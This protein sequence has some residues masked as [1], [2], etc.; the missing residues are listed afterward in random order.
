M[1]P[2]TRAGGFSEYRGVDAL[3]M[4]LWLAVVLLSLILNYDAIAALRFPDADDP[5]RLAQV[6]DLIAGQSWF[7]IR[8]YRVNPLEGGGLMHWSRF[9]D[10]S[11]A[12]L[13]LPLQSLLGETAGERWAITLYPPLLLLPLFLLIV[14]ILGVLGDRRLVVAGLLVAFTGATFLHFFIPMRIDHH[15]WQLLLS[16]AMVWIALRPPSLV[17]GLLGAAIITLYVEISLEGLPYLLL[18]G[19][20]FAF[21]WLRNSQTSRRLTGF[22]F[23]LVGFPAL[24]LLAMRGARSALTVFCDTFSLPYAAAVA[25]S[26]AVVG[27]WTLGPASL[28]QSLWYRLFAL[29]AAGAAGATAFV[30]SGP[31]CLAGP[32]GALDPL[33]RHHW[34]DR[35]LEGRPVWADQASYGIIY[36]VP[37]LVGLAALAYAWRRS[38]GGPFAENWTRVAVIILGSALMSALV[39]RTGATTHALLVPAFATM[40]LALWDWSRSR[41]S[42]A[43]RSA[44]ILLIFAASPGADAAL[45]L[46]LVRAMSD[47]TPLMA[48]A[49][50]CPSIVNVAALGRQP[51]ARL[52]APID[53]GP[54]LLAYTPHSVVAT[55]HHR[56]NRAMHRVIS[57][58]IA[59]PAIAEP[60]V[61]AERARYLVICRGLPEVQRFASEAPHG[62][63][64]KLAR[65]ETVGWL[66][67]D[68]R[69][70]SESLDVYRVAPPSRQVVESDI[71]GKDGPVSIH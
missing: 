42:L 19:G 57:A 38:R 39:A 65:G 48:S 67:R 52:F 40:A 7:D 70:S 44:S 43:G 14:R 66:A 55:G 45:G 68:A 13:I 53:I 30:L 24:W 18:F 61:R 64:A 47:E 51:A 26:A 9:V 46:K 16:M 62:L 69:L 8:Q 22:A 1:Y 56:N 3:A 31:Q 34:Y 11:I 60:I 20:L 25:A 41:R 59:E 50:N 23:G 58:F 63:A 2:A 28:R 15:N 37:T 4:C 33:V 32:F 36:L 6:R 27:A 12:G 21:D 35:V 54:A 5:M 29:P 49:T 71:G 17:N 10:A